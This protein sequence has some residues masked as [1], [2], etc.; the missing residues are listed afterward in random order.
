MTLLF[1]LFIISAALLIVVGIYS[2]VATRN[3][4]RILL[5][6]E[7]LTKAVSLVI[8]GAGY[9]TGKMAAAQSYMI[10]IIV[11]EV[12]LLVVA[13]GIVFGVYKNTASI[14]TTKI[15]DLKG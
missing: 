13:T 9:E 2:L 3:L 11:I 6:I 1:I 15:N 4:M 12:M 14:D 5:S 7:I 10:T 8:I